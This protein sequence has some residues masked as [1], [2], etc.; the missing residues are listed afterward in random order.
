MT[1]VFYLCRAI[2][3]NRKIAH[4]EKLQAFT[5]EGTSEN[6]HAVRL[7]PKASCTCP[8]AG[9][10]CYHILAAKMSIEMVEP[11]FQKSI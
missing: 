10:F 6:V 9:S 7:F 8:A 11:L 2:I 1:C 3:D 4:N 5:L